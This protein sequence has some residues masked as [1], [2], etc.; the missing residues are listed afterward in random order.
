MTC[1]QIVK[2]VPDSPSKDF[3][4]PNCCFAKHLRVK[5][6]DEKIGFFRSYRRLSCPTHGGRIAYQDPVRTREPAI[7]WPQLTLLHTPEDLTAIADACTCNH[8][9]LPVEH[10]NTGTT[11]GT[12]NARLRRQLGP[13]RPRTAPPARH[14]RRTRAPQRSFP[15]ATRRTHRSSDRHRR[16]VRQH[17]ST[18]ATSLARSTTAR[19]PDTFR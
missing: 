6:K 7:S 13:P 5:Q 17:F 10:E 2:R 4:P 14:E 11:L 18:S 1:S 19:N 9:T 15:G 8:G 12:D 3:R 16:R